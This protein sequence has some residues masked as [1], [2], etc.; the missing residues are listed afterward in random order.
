MAFEIFNKKNS[1]FG[2]KYILRCH[3][4]MFMFNPKA[5]VELVGDNNYLELFYDEEKKLGAIQFVE[6]GSVKITHVNGQRCCKFGASAF[7]RAVNGKEF[8]LAPE[9]K[10]W[11]LKKIA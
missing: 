11:V 8:E 5:T 3:K 6:I 4:T 10:L 7:A 9:G 2:D 1:R